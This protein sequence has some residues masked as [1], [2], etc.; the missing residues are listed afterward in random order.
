M[1]VKEWYGAKTVYQIESNTVQSPQ[2]LYE[3][4]IIV[5]KAASFDDAICEAEREAGLYANDASG[6]RYLG[7][8]NV[9]KLFGEEIQDKTEVFSLM[10]ESELNSEEYIDRHLDTGTERTK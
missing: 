5:L 2:K 4:R 6:I 7:Y 10:R 1:E 9:F 3:E 8:V